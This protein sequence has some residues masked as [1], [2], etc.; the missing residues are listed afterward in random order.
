MTPPCDVVSALPPVVTPALS[1]S[2]SLST[3]ASQSESDWELDD[4]DEVLLRSDAVPWT[5]DQDQALLSVSQ[6]RISS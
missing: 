1:R 6:L 3:N 5:Q 2:S 4:E